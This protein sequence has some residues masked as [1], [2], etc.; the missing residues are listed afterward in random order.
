VR[1]AGV[2][3]ATADFSTTDKAGQNRTQTGQPRSQAGQDQGDRKDPPLETRTVPDTSPT[4]A[5]RP[6][7][8]IKAQQ[9]HN[10]SITGDALSEDLQ[11]LV[12]LWP[13]LSDKLRASI[14]ALVE[15]S[16]EK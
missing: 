2:E 1:A 3:P 9:E 14:L 8:T 16:A 10:I 11:R 5:G 12:K 6:E 15:A 13:S 4:K 7:N